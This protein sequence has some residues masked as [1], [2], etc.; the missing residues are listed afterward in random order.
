MKEKEHKIE[1]QKL[2]WYFVLFSMVGLVLETIFCYVTTGV[3]E[4]RKGLIWGPF[5]PVYGVGAVF[6]IFFLEHVEQKKYFKLFLYGFLIGSVIEYLLSYG[7]EEIYVTRFW[8]YSYTQKDINGRICVLYSLFWGIL[9]IL[10][11]KIAKPKIDGL[12][13]KIPTK[14]NTVGAIFILIF[15]IL[16]VIVT[17][18][19]I[20]TYETRAIAQY[21]HEEIEVE[22]NTNWLEEIKNQIEN[23]YFTN[24]RMKRIFP[25]LR[26]K[27]REG[28]EI[29]L[30]DMVQ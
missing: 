17:I 10:L 4:S 6:L 8:D 12:I 7:L 5:C 24:E 18:W 27:D 13:K 26:M 22:E 29:W 2:F 21:Y 11:M 1:I 15:L 14:M 23:K 19:A 25:N 20:N 3:I 30:I 16:D 28:K 9:A